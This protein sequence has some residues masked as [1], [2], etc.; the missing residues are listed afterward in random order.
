MWFLSII[1]KK[2]NSR[3]S[4]FKSV[5]IIK[6]LLD[7]KV[8][9]LLGILPCIYIS[10]YLIY[11]ILINYKSYSLFFIY[12]I[13]YRWDNKMRYFS[14]HCRVGW[15][16]CRIM[17]VHKTLFGNYIYCLRCRKLYIIIITSILL[18]CILQKSKVLG[19]IICG[20]FFLA[21]I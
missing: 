10:T 6:V 16:T 7:K 12:Y 14:H 15:S 4:E 17:S 18:V 11:N 13:G 8:I 1:T 20:N 5:Y 2:Y 3:K 9:Y 19:Y 21:R